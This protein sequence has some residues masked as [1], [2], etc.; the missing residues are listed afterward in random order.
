MMRTHLLRRASFMPQ[1]AEHQGQAALGRSR[2]RAMTLIE[3]LIA[4]A[5]L[6]FISILVFLSIDG[7]RRS[8]EGCQGSRTPWR[9]CRSWPTS[10]S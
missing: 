8:R 7:M 6:A 4:M 2:L 9:I 10:R 5:I 3:L 1:R